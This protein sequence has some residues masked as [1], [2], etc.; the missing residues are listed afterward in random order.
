MAE[1]TSVMYF[2]NVVKF[3]KYIVYIK[4]GI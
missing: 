2:F 4:V 1:K 3:E